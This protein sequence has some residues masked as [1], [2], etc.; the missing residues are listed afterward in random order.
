MQKFLDKLNYLRWFIFNLSGKISGFAAIL[1][2]KN[3]ANFTLGAKQQ[4][5]FDDIKKY[6]SSSPVMKAPKV[7]IPFWLYIAAEDSM[8][9]VVLTPMMDGKEYI[10]A[11][12]I[13]RLIDA[14]TRYSFYWK[15][16]FL[17]VPN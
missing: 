6:L 11:Y 3:E 8:I 5:T 7:R 12:L 14:K 13:W 10:I 15:V 4:L 9:G 16:T 1:H 2:L 17:L